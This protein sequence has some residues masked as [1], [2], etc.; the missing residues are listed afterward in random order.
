MCIKSGHFSEDVLQ[1]IEIH[2]LITGYFLCLALEGLFTGQNDING[3]TRMQIEFI[4][5][6]LAGLQV[7]N[8]EQ[9][10]KERPRIGFIKPEG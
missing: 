3:D 9:I 7:K 5:Q 10:G 2:S 1:H 6:T 4:N 8:K